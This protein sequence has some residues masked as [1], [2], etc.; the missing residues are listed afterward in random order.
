MNYNLNLR[1]KKK[2]NT[3]SFEKNDKIKLHVFCSFLFLS[4]FIEKS[5]TNN[6]Y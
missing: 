6:N 1:F 3:F 4:P 2:K 5:K